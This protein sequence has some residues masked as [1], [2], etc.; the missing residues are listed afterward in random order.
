MKRINL[1]I[2]RIENGLTQTE[3]AK[4][5]G[6]ANQTIS[7]Y[8]SGRTDPSYKMMKRISEELNSSVDYLFF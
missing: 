2:R 3:L 4:K 1:T 8:E 5:V 6:V 7:D